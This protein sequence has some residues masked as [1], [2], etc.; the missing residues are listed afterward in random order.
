M[1]RF[2]STSLAGTSTVEEISMRIS[3][4][5]RGNIAISV[6]LADAAP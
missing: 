1:V 6:S 2:S 3:L 5:E 4:I